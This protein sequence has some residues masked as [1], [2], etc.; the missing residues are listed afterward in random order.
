[1]TRPPP[2][3]IYRGMRTDLLAWQWQAYSTNH[4]DRRNLVLHI[5]TVPLFIAGLATGIAGPILGPWWLA[6]AGLGGMVS[7]LAAQGRGHRG[8]RTAPIP[9]TGGGDF[10][11]RFLAEQ[12]VSFPRFVVSGG[13]LRAWRATTGGGDAERGAERR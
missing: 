7:A 8:E 10:V 6:L 13:W 4:Q 9:F 12:L 2:G 11:T 3:L 5:I 1:M